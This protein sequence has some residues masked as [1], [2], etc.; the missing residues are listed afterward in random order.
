MNR[1]TPGPQYSRIP[2]PR[3]MAAGGPIL[4]V[5]GRFHRGPGSH[6]R[7]SILLAACLLGT[8]PVTASA[9]E[10]RRVVNDGQLILEGV[11][12]IPLDLAASLD[13]YQDTR[14][15]SLLEFAADGTSLFVRRQAREVDQV[16][17][18][19]GRGAKPEPLTDT[20]D[21]VGEVARQRNGRLLAFTLDRGGS[22]QDQIWLLDPDRGTTRRL[23]RGDSLNNRLA[24]D[25]S[26]HRLAFRSTRRN[27]RS[28]DI[29]ILDI[30]HPDSARM[31]LA[32]PDS[33]LW[34][35]VSFSRDG[36]LL[37]VQQYKA[38]NDSR[39]HLLD[40]ET[41]LLRELVGHPEYE[42][43]NIGI[44]FDH[45]DTGVFFVTNQRNGSAEIGWAPLDPALPAQYVSRSVA[46]DVTEFELAPDGLRGA[47]VTNENGV[48]RLYLFDAV[49]F[50]FRMIKGTPLGVI[51]DLRFSPDGRRLGLSVS[52]PVS[53]GDVQVISLGRQGLRAGRPRTWARG[54][55]AGFDRKA[56]VEPQLFSFPA[57]GL[58]E[59]DHFNMP[60]FAYLPRG[61]GPFPVVIWVHGG[62]ESQYRPAFNETVQ[63]WVS[64]LGVAVLAPNVRG[65]MGY[66]RGYLA[67]DD[68]IRREDAVRDIGALLDWIANQRR[69]DASRV[70]V[71]G[72]SYG[73]YMALAS[74]V[75][76]SDRL[77]AAI[78]R[79]GIS[80]FVTYL[81][82]TSDYR[83]DLRRYEYGDERDPDMRAYLTEISPLNNVDRISIPMLIVQGQ[84]DPV[85]PASESEQMVRALRERG[86]TVWYMNA[87]NEGHGYERKD[88]QDVYEQ[89]S[90][91]FLQRFL[92][93]ED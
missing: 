26:G 87:L 82:N 90:Y 45:G 12:P 64:Q 83:R 47:F 13:R 92:L 76:Y 37:L 41:G 65:S 44:D 1:P 5:S 51:S 28:N 22:E 23:T 53:P 46:W 52:T 35:P 73:G 43:A 8:F 54:D 77:S 85:V 71:F 2:P 66:G 81:E 57:P 27:G 38:I 69:L 32:A 42:T 56:F 16:Y 36:R 34:K 78:D 17:R 60:G 91:L 25:H 74:A 58:T 11:P 7:A 55:V 19:S 29:W 70:A 62:P 63:A 89:V 88:N 59:D 84:N 49:E 61:R 18:L 93:G 15:M 39:V 72:S 9:E 79:S 4:A 24:W 50:R 68:G 67:L 80:H 31:V 3:P 75:H 10:S 20:R 6:R 30:R 21:P 14:S 40:L 33:A 48:S 86:Q